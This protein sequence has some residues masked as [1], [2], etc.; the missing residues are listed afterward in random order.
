[1]DDVL[2]KARAL[3]ALTTSSNID[4]ARNAALAL[5]RLIQARHLVI[6][7]GAAGLGTTFPKPSIV[8]SSKHQPI[9]PSAVRTKKEAQKKYRVKVKVPPS[10]SEEGFQ[11]M[12]SKFAGICKG[13]VK[14][15]KINSPIYWSPDRGA[16]HSECFAKT[17]LRVPRG[18]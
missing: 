17:T 12:K 11:K 8:A 5:A 14:S 6:S 3:L 15:I 18:T 13:C 4:E 10:D 1:V 9:S 16:Y 7:I 2:G